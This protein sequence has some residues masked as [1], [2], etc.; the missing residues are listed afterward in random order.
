MFNPKHI[1]VPVAVAAPDDIAIAQNLVDTATDV[2]RQTG[3]AMTIAY[4]EPLA[5]P[6]M[7]LDIGMMPP[8]AMEA[9]SSL[10]AA[11]TAAAKK[12][13]HDLLERAKK[14]GVRADARIAE[15]TTGV[16]ES[17]VHVADDAKCDLIIVSSH[18][19]KGVSRLLL[20]SVAER[21]A[22]LS[23]VPVLLIHA[24]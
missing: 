19:R 15:A 3:A 18:G 17:I 12:N 8:N 20:G 10:R 21:T 9:M 5:I 2:A 11:N 7:P 6:T 1:L 14:A 22:H 24:G 23:T 13:L 16:G 4:I